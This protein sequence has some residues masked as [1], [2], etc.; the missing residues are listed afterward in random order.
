MVNERVFSKFSNKASVS[1][2]PSLIKFEMNVQDTKQELKLTQLTDGMI[3]YLIIL[4][5]ILPK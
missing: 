3:I 1:T 2:S 4:W 5:N